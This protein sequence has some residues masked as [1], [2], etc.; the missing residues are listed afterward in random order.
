MNVAAA[1]IQ[2]L[3]ASFRCFIFGLLAL[4]P[5]IGILFAILAL[6]ISAKVRA[7]QRQF[8]NPARPYWICGIICASAGFIFWSFFL[9]LIVGHAMLLV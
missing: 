1:K 2:M 8:W 7:S 5:V 3:N 9:I 6:V 4:L